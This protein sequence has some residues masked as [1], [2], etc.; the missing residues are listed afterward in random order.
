MTY[1]RRVDGNHAELKG[2]FEK[3]GCA[4]HDAS[5]AGGGFPDL[6]VS[7]HRQ[8]VLVEVKN[9]T[10]P[11]ADQELTPEQTRFHREWKGL[12]YQARTL[13]DVIAIVAELKKNMRMYA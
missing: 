5:R 1:A 7:L 11:K 10:K 4:V 6:V 12:I 2:Y 13:D 3:L 9:P 8:T